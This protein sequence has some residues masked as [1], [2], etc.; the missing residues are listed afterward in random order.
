MAKKKIEETSSPA[1][2]KNLILYRA[3][4]KYKENHPDEKY[5][6][7][8]LIYEVLHYYPYKPE[9]KV[10]NRKEYRERKTK[11]C[12]KE[13]KIYRP[14]PE[15]FD[16][17][18]KEY[19]DEVTKN[20][21]FD[22]DDEQCVAFLCGCLLVTEYESFFYDKKCRET[23]IESP[24]FAKSHNIQTGYPLYFEKVSEIYY[25]IARILEVDEDLI[26]YSFDSLPY[27]NKSF[28]RQQYIQETLAKYLKLVKETASS[29]SQKTDM[30][31]STI[32][33]LLNGK[34]TFTLKQFRMIAPYLN[35][36]EDVEERCALYIAYL[37]NP[38]SFDFG[39]QHYTRIQNIGK[40]L[41]KETT[42]IAPV[43]QY[44]TDNRP[45]GICYRK[46]SDTQTVE[47]LKPEELIWI[48]VSKDVLDKP[49]I[50]ELIGVSALQYIGKL[51][52]VY[53]EWDRE[54]WLSK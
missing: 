48:E 38:E 23:Y 47:L 54:G 24:S 31:H 53:L 19:Y 27:L 49:N 26:L 22:M 5:D 34:D 6:L 42:G 32:S 43:F 16:I 25:A 30:G 28:Y 9:E 8:T 10:L 37:Q 39:F 29:L 13:H 44:Y 21:H 40:N 41:S 7:D 17:E 51:I 1:L 15:W 4:Q 45:E 14:L 12:A 18:Y 46:S 33:K 36:P 11:A 2:D 20:Y 35:L 3:Y 50:S 52:G